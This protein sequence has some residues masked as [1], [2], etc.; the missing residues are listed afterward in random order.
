MTPNERFDE[1]GCDASEMDSVPPSDSDAADSTLGSDDTLSASDL[2]ASYPR[3]QDP[4]LDGESFVAGREE[5]TALVGPNGSGKSTLL[6]ALADQLT[7]DDGKVLLQGREIQELE[8]KEVARRLGMLS[9]E[10][11][12]PDSITVEDL[13]FHGRYPHRG[14][15][16]GVTEEDV[17][18]VD[19]ALELAGCEHLRD[20]ELGSLSGGQR[21]LAWIAMVLAQDT[22]VLL[23]DEPTTYL[24]LHHQ[25][26]VI[27]VIER[28]RDER[29]VTVVV[30][31]H[32]IQQAARLADRMVV[33][34]EGRVEAT[35]TPGEVVREGLI[36][37]VFEVEAEVEFTD[38]GPR[39]EPLCARHDLDSDGD[40]GR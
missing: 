27:E 18:S 13:V 19:R 20:R 1:D 24:D 33:M 28:L 7:P 3:T 6:K 37:E 8:T 9:Q 31:L 5:V 26:E 23:L 14:F 21:Q 34:K 25:M 36:A 16:E 38:R 12:S 40:H 4:V 30:V 2:V 39:I 35:G 22:E 15:F 10:A 17:D 11:T 29:D 32:D